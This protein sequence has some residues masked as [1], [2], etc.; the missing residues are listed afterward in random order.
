MASS[1]K[2][3]DNTDTYGGEQIHASTYSIADIGKLAFASK[4]E[5]N[6]PSVASSSEH[7]LDGTWYFFAPDMLMTVSHT[8]VPSPSFSFFRDEGHWCALRIV[9]KGALHLQAGDVDL[10]EPSISFIVTGTNYRDALEITG[11][12]DAP[13]SSVSILFDIEVLDKK[14]GPRDSDA[15]THLLEI[16]N[17]SSQEIGIYCLD[18][19]PRTVQSAANIIALKEQDP[20]CLL[21]AESEALT[22]LADLLGDLNLLIYKDKDAGINRKDIELLNRVKTKLDTDFGQHLSINDLSK[23]AGV[24][25]RKLTEGFKALFG[26]TI[27]EYLNAVR[28]C[29]AVALLEQKAPISEIALLTGF[30]EHASFTRA[31]KRYYGVLPKDFV[32]ARP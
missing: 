20:Y 12:A 28:M 24:N 17:S 25:R 21:R 30:S 13:L 19:T 22:L 14:L 6:L 9:L 8:T 2:Q 26:S 10:H 16:S 3:T 18:H 5:R 27:K 23:Y 4:K 11:V 29:H 1:S 31:F 32:V 15:I 7:G